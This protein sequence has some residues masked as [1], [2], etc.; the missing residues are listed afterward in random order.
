MTKIHIAAVIVILLAGVAAAAEKLSPFTAVEF[1]GHTPFVQYDGKWYE[2]LEMEGMKAGEIVGFCR[3]TWPGKWQKRFAEDLF[4][5]L[6]RMGKRPGRS[7]RLALRSKESGNVRRVSKARMTEENRRAVWVARNKRHPRSK[8]KGRLTAGDAASD[9]RFLRE[10]LMEHHSYRLRIPDYLDRFEWTRKEIETREFA[11]H[12][13]RLLA[14]LGDGHTRV[15]GRWDWLPRGYLP[16]RVGVSGKRLVAL[17]P[18]G[19]RLLDA[20][21]P[22]LRALDGFPVGKWLHS[23]QSIVAQGSAQYRLWN[24]A[25]YL[26]FLG[27]LRRELGLDSAPK[28]RVELE[29]ES[30]G[31]LREF[32]LPLFERPLPPATLPAGR[33]RTLPGNIGYLRIPEMDSESRFLDSME[34]AMDGFRSTRGL[35]LDVRGAPS[36]ERG[37]V[38]PPESGTA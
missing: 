5:V 13:A 37:Q 1:E 35:I 33:T 29:S 31:K 30:G 22:Y 32:E 9:M 18:T 36:G 20:Q 24:G 7:V 16:F 26:A 2:L 23:T 19:R 3:K 38:S 21:R 4:E 10:F 28:V 8:P 11:L 14:P 34:R 25:E 12:L 17:D 15:R 27:F 6:E